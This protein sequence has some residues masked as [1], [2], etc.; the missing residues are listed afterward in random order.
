MPMRR[1]RTWL[2][3]LLPLAALAVPAAWVGAQL[4]LPTSIKS[5]YLTEKNFRAGDWVLYEVQ[6]ENHEGESSFDHQKIQIA[7]EV[8][9]RG[10]DCFWLETGWGPYIDDLAWTAVLMSETVFDDSLAEVRTDVHLRQMHMSNAPDGRPLVGDARLANAHRPM[11]DLTKLMPQRTVIGRDTVNV[12][13]RTFDCELQEEIQEYSEAQDKADST[14]RMITKT[15]RR[16]WM[17]PKIPITGMAREHER[18]EFYR[19]AWPLGRLSTEFPMTMV[20]FYELRVQLVDLGTGAKPEIS[21]RM[22]PLGSTYQ[23]EGNF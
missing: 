9:F 20:K 10:D 3:F 16:R 15:H 17:N 13:N 4:D 1:P 22:I 2:R 14:V 8:R 6:A 19:H 21:D 12:G 5:L 11:G 23:K 7:S 18:K